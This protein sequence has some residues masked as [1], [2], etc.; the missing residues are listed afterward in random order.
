LSVSTFNQ[1]LRCP[2]SFYYEQV[3]KVPTVFSEAATYGTAIHN[4]LQVYFEKVFTMPRAGFPPAEVLVSLFEQ[5]LQRMAGYLSPEAFRYRLQLG[6]Q[7]LPGYHRQRQ[8]VWHNKGK[9]ELEVKQVEVNGV[10]IKGVIDKVELLKG[11]Q[12]RIFDYK[13]GSLNENKLRRPTP[14]KPYGGI[15]W[16]QLVFYKILLEGIRTRQYQVVE[17]GID[18]VQPD[19][20][21]NYPF[22]TIGIDQESVQQMKTWIRE[23]YQQIRA[24]DF[25]QGCGEEH[26]N[27]CQF[28]RIKRQAGSFSDQQLEELDD[29]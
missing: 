10:P 25:Y 17:A 26:C 14:A 27:W 16:R 1:Y 6:R 2:L 29:R 12:A 18:Y 20:N 23:V 24:H 5:E 11:D 28:E 9:L 19:Q 4:A 3:L 22:Q 13:T 15:Y 21:G 8:S 7:H